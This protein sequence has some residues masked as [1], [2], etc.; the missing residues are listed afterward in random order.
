MGSLRLDASAQTAL[1]AYTWPGN[2]RELEHLIG[3]SVLKALGEQAKRPRILTLSAA[4]LGL[5]GPVPGL[6]AAHEAAAP[7]ASSMAVSCLKPAL[8]AFQRQLI[9]AS[10]A[11]HQH[12][13]AAAARE[14]G[15]DRANLSRLARRLGIAAASAE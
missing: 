14:L 15:L 12:N 1:Q 9:D 10:L 13:L 6:S 4:A 8:E 5:P 7:L 2:V 11:R 3:R